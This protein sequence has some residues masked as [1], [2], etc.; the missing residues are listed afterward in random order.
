MKTTKIV[1]LAGLLAFT[2]SAAFAADAPKKIPDLKLL[3]S[4]MIRA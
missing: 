4:T 2:C 3:T 1:I